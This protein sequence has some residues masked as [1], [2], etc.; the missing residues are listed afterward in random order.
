MSEVLLK[1]TELTRR[2]GGLVAVDR[3][4]S[5]SCAARCMRSSAPTARARAR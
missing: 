1:A 5:S 4:R 3:F 2:F